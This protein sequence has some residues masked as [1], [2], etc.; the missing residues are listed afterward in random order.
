MFKLF[1]VHSILISLSLFTLSQAQST[2]I[3]KIRSISPVSRDNHLQS[4]Q[5][6]SAA[7]PEAQFSLPISGRSK[8]RG[9]KTHLLEVLRHAITGERK[10]GSTTALAASNFDTEYLVNITIGG[11]QF[12]MVMDT[13]SSDLWVPTTNFTCVNLTS[14]VVSQEECL[15]GPL[16]NPSSSKSFQSVPDVNFKILYGGGEFVTGTAGK[17]TVTIAGMTVPGQEF[18]VVDRATWFGDG[19]NSGTFGLAYPLLTSVYPGTDSSNDF[20]PSAAAYTPFPF[21]AVKKG[22][23]KAPFFSIALNRG[24]FQQETQDAFDPNF[25]FLSFGGMPPVPVTKISTVAPIQGYDITT[26]TPSNTT[27]ATSLFYTVD[28]Q[29]FAFAGSNLTNSTFNN[30]VMFDTGATLSFLPTFIADAFA[31]AVNP[32]GQFD[33]NQGAYVT[34]CDAVVPEFYVRIHDTTFTVDPRDNILPLGT[35]E[36]GNEV[37]MLG[38]SDGGSGINGG[39]F[40]L[41]DSFLHNV[42]TTFDIQENEITITQRQNY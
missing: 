8:R 5:L 13:G 19:I 2:P 31:A 6:R 4:A 41:G 30:N 7:I 1:S 21:T 32:P 16:F 39:L 35:D 26:F 28:I 22:I 12:S 9:V 23:L 17:D 40:I 27:N 20:F 38:T 25:G 24:T 33:P 18:G 11:S 37:C 36:D 42:V 29:E 3:Y 10:G 34:S 15:F 14:Q